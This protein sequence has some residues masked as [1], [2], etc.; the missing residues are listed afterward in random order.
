MTKAQIV[1]LIANKSG[2]RKEDVL[3][4]LETFMVTVKETMNDGENVF[5]RGFGTFQVTLRRPKLA[6]NI[7]KN[8]TVNIPGHFLPTFRPAKE[9]AD[10]VK[11]NPENAKRVAE[12]LAELEAK[13]KAKE[14]R[15]A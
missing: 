8:T 7:S 2:Q 5:L 13:K 9:F 4:I 10:D 11:N 15:K 6:R 3:N 12:R 14:S 1:E